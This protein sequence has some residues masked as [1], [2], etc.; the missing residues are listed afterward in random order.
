WLFLESYK[1]IEAPGFRPLP[2]SE[3]IGKV[4]QTLVLTPTHTASR[5][6]RRSSRPSVLWVDDRPSNNVFERRTL[7]E[8]GI[9][10]TISTSTDDALGKLVQHHYDA[11][12]SDMGRPPD[13]RAGYTLLEAARQQGIRIPYII[14]ASSDRPEHTAEAVS[15]GAFGSTGTPS[16]LVD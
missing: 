14:Y 11:I 10:I 7:E 5:H 6:D 8:E 2:Q 15:R 13:S 1:R 3:A 16:T 12:I 4:L 9:D